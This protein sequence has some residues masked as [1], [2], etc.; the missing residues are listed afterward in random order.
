MAN[1][2]MQS[3][4]RQKGLKLCKT[5]DASFCQ[6][7]MPAIIDKRRRRGIGMAL[8]G[9]FLFLHTQPGVPPVN[10][11]LYKTFTWLKFLNGSGMQLRG[12]G[13]LK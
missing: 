11:K 9:V 12:P 4:R 13:H 5:V 10:L 7:K 8:I 1:A 2:C 3:C 6:N